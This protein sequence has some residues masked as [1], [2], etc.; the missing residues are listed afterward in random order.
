MEITILQA[1]HDLINQSNKILITFKKDYSLDTVASALALTLFLKKLDKEVMIVCEKTDF[2][3]EYL[4]LPQ[5]EEIKNGLAFVEKSLISINISKTKIKEFCYTLEEERLNIFVTHEKGYFAPEEISNLSISP[6]DLI[7]VLNT[8]NLDL[9]GESFKNHKKIFQKP[10]I[11][12]DYHQENKKFGQINFIDS[13][14][15]CCSEIIFKL[16]SYF[17]KSY[18]GD[19][20]I[21]TCLLNGMISDDN[22]Y[23]VPIKKDFNLKLLAKALTK[24]KNDPDKKIS[25]TI[26]NQEDFNNAQAE[27]NDLILL[28][29]ELL[30]YLR[31]NKLL[32]LFYEN[33]FNKINIQ[34]LSPTK[35]INLLEK[36]KIFNPRGSF[37]SVEFFIE[38]KSL[39]EVEESVIAEI[40][41]S[42]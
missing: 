14:S 41:K 4:S 15:T 25:W 34:A 7:F 1:V 12:L 31:R 16:I 29:K 20:K 30:N 18:C 3:S 19:E 24:L 11:N 22:N 6:F 36:F 27:E 2:P 42:F 23:F 38:N 10:I 13:E 37:H 28:I 8:Q 26:L 33:E 39:T 9:L 5:I 21:K 35:E 32:I 40:G 17:N